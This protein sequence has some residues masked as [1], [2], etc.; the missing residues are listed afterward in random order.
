MKCSCVETGAAVWPRL[1]RVA[2][3]GHTEMWG[4]CWWF[5]GSVKCL[6]CILAFLWVEAKLVQRAT[7]TVHLVDVT[8]SRWHL[9]NSPG[10]RMVGR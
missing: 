1:L 5:P 10:N 8:P 7:W 6:A 3:A 4:V 9:R 2:E